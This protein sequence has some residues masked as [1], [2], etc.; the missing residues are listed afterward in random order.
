MD[1]LKGNHMKKAS[2]TVSLLLA[3]LLAASGAMAQSTPAAGSSDVPPKAGE[4]STQTLGV[5]NAA[6][7]NSA[8]TDAPVIAKDQV[9][10]GAQGAGAA[11]AT[12]SVPG[13]AGEAS[14]M[15]NGQP[16]AKDN[17]P[18]LNKSK[19]E[20]KTEKEM[21]KAEAQQRREMAI[22]SQ[23]GAQVGAPA[24]TPAVS[25]AGT[26]SVHKGGTPK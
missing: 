18:L 2:T 4:A 6:T 11:S 20:R 10:M 17:D 1:E 9:R 19:A 16:N 8:V 13:K 24:G 25:P 12:T 7:T 15:V 22:M 14:T 21:K 26:P 3:G 5:P 23:K